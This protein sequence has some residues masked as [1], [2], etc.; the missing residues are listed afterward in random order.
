[1]LNNGDLIKFAT[2]PPSILLMEWK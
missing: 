1:M 2:P